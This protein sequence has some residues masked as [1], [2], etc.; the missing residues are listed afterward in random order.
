MKHPNNVIEHDG[1]VVVRNV[2]HLLD[3]E[4]DPKLEPYQY[5]YY[6]TYHEHDHERNSAYYNL[7][8]VNLHGMGYVHDDPAYYLCDCGARVPDVVLGAL[9]LIEWSDEHACIR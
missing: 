5:R 2:S 6:M 3:I 7:C 4:A 9:T 8:R 1:W